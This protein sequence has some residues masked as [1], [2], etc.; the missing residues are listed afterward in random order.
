MSDA[1]AWTWEPAGI[2]DCGVAIDAAEISRDDT[3]ALGPT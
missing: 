3:L 1:T 2:F